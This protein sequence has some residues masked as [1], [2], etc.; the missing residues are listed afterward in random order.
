MGKN[1]AGKSSIMDALD[2]FLNDGSPDKHDAT[3]SGDA[4]DLT[5]ICEFSDLP[6]EVINHA[7]V[8]P[9]PAAQSRLTVRACFN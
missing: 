6:S 1:D 2:I 8:R 9:L 4:K 5:I 7:D 3:I